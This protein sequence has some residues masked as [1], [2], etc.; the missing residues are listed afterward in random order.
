MKEK[1]TAVIR[2]ASLGAALSGRY[3]TLSII[4]FSEPLTSIATTSVTSSP[5]TSAA[6]PVSGVRPSVPHSA[7]D[8]NAPIM[9]ISPWAKLISSMIP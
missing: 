3:P 8:V 4:T 9:K 2:G 6:V 5:A 1:P 7:N